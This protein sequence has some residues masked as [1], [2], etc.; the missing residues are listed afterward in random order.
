MV[1]N[2]H[3]GAKQRIHNKYHPGFFG[4]IFNCRYDNKSAN[5]RERDDVRELDER[6]LL[7]KRL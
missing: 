4:R 7:S 2:T 5:K 1:S 3:E 6:Y